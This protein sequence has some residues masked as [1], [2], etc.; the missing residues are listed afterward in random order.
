[1]TDE[2]NIDQLANEF[3]QAFR[4]YLEAEVARLAGIFNHGEDTDDK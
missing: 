1:M 3:L 2:E 4:R